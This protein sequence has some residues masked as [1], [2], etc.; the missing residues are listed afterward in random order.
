MTISWEMVGIIVAILSHA[1]TTIWWASKVSTNLLNIDRSLNRMDLE[2]EKRD[3]QI[4]RMWER[5][6]EVRD[7][8]PKI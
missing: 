5:I 4:A 6:D 2:L 1:G 3:V 7:M 8:I